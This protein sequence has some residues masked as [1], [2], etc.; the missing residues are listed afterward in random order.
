MNEKQIEMI[1]SYVNKLFQADTTG[2]DFYHLKRVTS[3]AKHIAKREQADI[4]LTVAAAWLHDVGDEK[5]FPDPDNA[6]RELRHFL[7]SIGITKE[8]IDSI[9]DIISNISFR[10]GKTPRSFEGK[11]VQDADRLDA[12]GAIGV[13][14]TFAYGGSVGQPIYHEEMNE[15][16]IQH[17]YDKLL[18]ITEL[19]HT[20]TA[21]QIAN[22][23]HQYMVDFLTRFEKEWYMMAD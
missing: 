21:K 6:R 4:S 18:K 20:S 13:A 7:F 11:I 16:S 8:D 10:K 15:H 19:M 5:L 23:R 22:D 3:L 9:F 12:I 2:H 14:R 1:K 17:F